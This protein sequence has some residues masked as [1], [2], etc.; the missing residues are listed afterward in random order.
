[1]RVLVTAQPAASHLRAVV[2]AAQAF[3]RGGHDVLVAAPELQRAD[4]ASYGLEMVEVAA[5]WPG[6][7]PRR[8]HITAPADV[9]ARMLGRMLLGERVLRRARELIRV[10]G[11]WRPDLVLRDSAELGGCLAGEALGVPHLSVQS[12]GARVIPQGRAGIA[13]A[14]DAHRAALGLPSDPGLQALFRYLHANLMP[15]EY[16]PAAVRMR[17]VRCYRQTRPE[18]ASEEPPAWLGELPEGRPVVLAA[19]GTQFHEVPGRVEALLAALAGV[20]CSAIVAVGQGK[21]PGAYGPQ[22]GHVRLVDVVAQPLVLQCCDVFLS[23]GGFNSVREALRAG[24]PMV[25]AP[26]TADQPGNA[27]RCAELGLARSFSAEPPPAEALAAACREVL[28]D[29]G[30]RARA[31]AMQRRIVALPPLDRLVEDAERLV[32]TGVTR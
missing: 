5:D 22:P 7:P 14:L 23:H 17:N 27:Q 21:D 1:M 25:I 24:V 9:R 3:R 8:A 6:Q 4:V 2:P 31:R 30:Y 10:A 15:P 16:D 13:E 20:D 32:A 28:E 26:V 19:L 18:R 29:P 12:T 11:D